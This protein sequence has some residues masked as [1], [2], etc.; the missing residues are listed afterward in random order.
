MNMKAKQI[1]L[2]IGV[3]AI[4]TLSFGQKNKVTDA[5]VEYKNTRL[6]FAMMSPD[7]DLKATVASLNKA[8]T[9]IDE[10]AQHE[11]TKNDQK[12][13]WYQGEIYTA[14]A[15]IGSLDS[16]AFDADPE[17]ALEKAIT[18][19]STGLNAGKKYQ[20]DI[21]DAT[22]N[23]SNIFVQGA[24]MAYNQKQ[25]EGAGEGFEYAAK[26]KNA[27]GDLDT[28]LYYNAAIS[29]DQA[30]K[31]EKA[32][33]NYSALIGHKSNSSEM[34]AS[35]SRNYRKAEMTDEAKAVVEKARATDPN[36]KDLLIELVNINLD[37]G[38]SEG[39]EKALS[40]AVAADPNNKT[41]HY[42]I[43]TVY[44][45]LGKK[46]EAEAELNKAIELDPKYEDAL[47]QL[48][49]HLVGWA[50]DVKLEAD[51]LKFGDPKYNQ[52]TAESEAIFNRAV[53]PLESYIVLQPNDKA[54]LNIL[55]KLHKN[56]GNTEKALEYK[57]RSEAAE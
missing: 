33:E 14:I 34:A 54:I 11:D 39:A 50:S 41:L 13:Y 37:K 48:G 44:M 36:N 53:T 45:D 27:G 9:A 21:Q 4:S 28:N 55:F 24:N 30:E 20:R 32:A 51:N 42:A 12:M 3:V 38:D 49:A 10:A 40:D 1:A 6:P 23:W 47:Y 22:T 57:R 43:G 26:F 52:L 8:K 15:V 18:S 5:A 2:S 46:A 25:F 31:F 19:Y 17:L 56:L 7:F 35:A 29:F 16:T